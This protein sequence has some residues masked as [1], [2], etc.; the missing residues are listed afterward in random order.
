[1]VLIGWVGRVEDAGTGALLRRGTSC[2][3]PRGTHSTVVVEETGRDRVRRY[4]MQ[5][6]RV[7]RRGIL[8]R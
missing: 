4:H 6:G 3:V 1:M 2:L 8:I 7:T 5:S